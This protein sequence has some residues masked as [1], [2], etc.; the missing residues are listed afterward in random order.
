MPRLL[1]TEEINKRLQ[2]LSGWQYKDCFLVKEIT[3]KTFLGGISFVNKLSK[4]AEKLEHHPDI[5]IRYN[6]V[7]LML[8][9]HS[10]N[11]VTVWDF[12]LAKEIDKLLSEMSKTKQKK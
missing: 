10:E 8:Q 4:I 12:Q 3:F 7:K 11:G 9:T 2:K 6:S 1:S 5:Y